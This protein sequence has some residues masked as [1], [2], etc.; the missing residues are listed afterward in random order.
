[1]CVRMKTEGK[2]L[3]EKLVTVFINSVCDKIY[4]YSTARKCKMCTVYSL[5]LWIQLSSS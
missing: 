3:E 1:M 2:V 5:I 4:S